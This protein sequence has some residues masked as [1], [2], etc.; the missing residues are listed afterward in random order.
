M[1]LNITERSA[2]HDYR[3]FAVTSGI[4]T[5]SIVRGAITITDFI[6]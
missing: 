5:C 2:I 3:D 6:Q 1:N 4:V